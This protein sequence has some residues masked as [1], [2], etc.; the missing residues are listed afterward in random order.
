MAVA[1]KRRWYLNLNQASTY[2]QDGERII[3]LIPSQVVDLWSVLAWNF[4]HDFTLSTTKRWIIRMFGELQSVCQSLCS[5]RHFLPIKD[6]NDAVLTGQG[7]HAVVWRPGRFDLSK[8]ADL[9]RKAENLH[10]R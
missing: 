7:D 6:A 1:C 5:R 3:V 8:T 4:K 10:S 9:R 2:S